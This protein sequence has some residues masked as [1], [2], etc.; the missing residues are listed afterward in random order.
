MAENNE[1]IAE[2]LQTVMILAP[3]I[4]QAVNQLSHSYVY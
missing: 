4:G 2:P 1:Q 3:K